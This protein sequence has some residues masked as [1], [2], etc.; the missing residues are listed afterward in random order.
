VQ[1]GEVVYALKLSTQSLMAGDR[2]MPFISQQLERSGVAPG[3]I[4]FE[5]N[6]SELTANFTRV[7]KL[8]AALK[9]LG[10]RLAIDRFG[11]NRMS[12][13]HLGELSVDFVKIDA[14]VTHALHDNPVDYILVETISRV[15]Q[16]M[17]IPVVATGVD[18]A[19]SLVEMEK[20]G[21]DYLL[22]DNIDSGGIL[23]KRVL[24]QT[25]KP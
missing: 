17:H 21:V 16:L 9:E 10:F 20:L 1:E 15:G 11:Y 13:G 2:L 4:C 14:G 6:E 5:V 25:E 22:G 19:Q 23:E 12:F 3:T 8:F 7:K 24:R 18:D